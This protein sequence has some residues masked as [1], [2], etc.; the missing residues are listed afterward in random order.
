MNINTAILNIIGK[1]HQKKFLTVDENEAKIIV[2]EKELFFIDNSS[3]QLASKVNLLTKLNLLKNNNSNFSEAKTNNLIEKLAT[4]FIRLNH[5]GISYFCKD[6]S[7]ELEEYKIAL[8]NTSFKMY[9]ESSEDPYQKW[10]FVGNINDWQAPLVEIVLNK[11][12]TKDY[13]EWV[14]HFQIDIDTNFSID[15]LETVSKEIFG[16]SFWK[17]KL[18]IPNY[19]VVLAMGLL[20]EIDGIKI[21]LGLGTN[22]RGTQYHRENLLIELK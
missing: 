19:G 4:K 1:L 13:Q 22:L 2:E 18:D 17:W 9:E 5:V 20:G 8:K 21:A 11:L 6:I 3:I 14:P 10:F 16:T 7:A 15:E 12:D